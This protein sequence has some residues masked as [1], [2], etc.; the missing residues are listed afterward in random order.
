MKQK[1]NALYSNMTK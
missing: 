1:K